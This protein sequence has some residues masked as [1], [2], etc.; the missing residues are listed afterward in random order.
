MLFPGAL[1]TV[2][3]LAGLALVFRGRLEGVSPDARGNAGF[4]AL[5]GGVAFWAS[6]GPS[7]GLYTWLFHAIPVFSFLRAPARFGIVVVLPLIVGLGYAAR[8][9]VAALAGAGRGPGRACSPWP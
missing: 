8:V 7:A 9:G 4:Y 6:F 3:G 5:F 1:T 2:I